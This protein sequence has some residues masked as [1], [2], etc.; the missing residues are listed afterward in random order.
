MNIWVMIAYIWVVGIPI[1]AVTLW[2]L[3]QALM[4]GKSWGLETDEDVWLALSIVWPV[5]LVGVAGFM[6][7]H[8]SQSIWDKQ[9]L[10]KKKEVKRCNRGLRSDEV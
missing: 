5:A 2:V 3:N 1:F 7:K 4:A 6:A 8:W 10:F 9:Y